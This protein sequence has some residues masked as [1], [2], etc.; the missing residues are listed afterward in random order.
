MTVTIILAILLLLA[1]A[2]ACWSFSRYNSLSETHRKLE[3]DVEQLRKTNGELTVNIARAEERLQLSETERQRERNDLENRFKAIANDILLN[4]SREISQQNTTRL[5]EVLQPMKENFELFRRTIT[6]SY[7][8]EA[9]ERFSLADRIKE[10]MELN[11]VISDETHR[12]TDALKG[13]SK[14]QGDW[15]EM[16]LENILERSGL[17]R[18]REF[19]VQQTTVNE[20]G[21]RLRP[22]VIINYPGDRKIIIDSKVSIQ[23]YLAMLDT[24]DPEKA[25]ALGKAHIA[26]IK[27]HITELRNKRYQ[28]Y[29]GDDKIDFVMMFIPHE[30][31]YLAAM[32]LDPTLWQTAYDSRVLIISPT[33]LMSVVKLVEQLWRHDRQTRNAIT[34]A[35]E[36]GR[37][38][39]KFRGFIDDMDK[40]DRNINSLR[41]SWNNAFGK[42]SSGNG[43]LIGRAEKLRKL[44]VKATKDLPE[45]YTNAAGLN[46]ADD[47]IQTEN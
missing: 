9:R 8:R 2:A 12:L 6:E 45:R 11:R 26:S 13:N 5:N 34:I 29:V 18:G 24:T 36:A 3:Y 31:A 30:G 33:H 44:G 43:N 47:D 40:M 7:D 46:A 39:D 38:L 22:D 19:E 21:A 20:S 17:E 4:N 27:N 14:M 15:G 35:E 42:L 25:A 16:I 28:D 32:Q 23:A 41:D 37:M 1:V 10:L